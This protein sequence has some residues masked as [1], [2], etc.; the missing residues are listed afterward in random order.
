MIYTVVNCCTIKRKNKIFKFVFSF[1]NWNFPEDNPWQNNFRYETKDSKKITYRC[2]HD[3]DQKLT[4]RWVIIPQFNNPN[5]SSSNHWRRWTAQASGCLFVV[6]LM[7]DGSAIEER[8]LPEL[9]VCATAVVRWARHWAGGDD[10]I[11]TGQHLQLWIAAAYVTQVTG[12]RGTAWDR[13]RFHR[14]FHAEQSGDG[15]LVRVE[16]DLAQ[17]CVLFVLLGGDLL[18]NQLAH[19]TAVQ[20][21][22]QLHRVQIGVQVAIVRC[23]L[24]VALDLTLMCAEVPIQIGINH[25]YEEVVHLLQA[26]RIVQRLQWSDR[27]R[28]ASL[29]FQNVL[30]VRRTGRAADHGGAEQQTGADRT[31]TRE[32]I[33][34]NQVTWALLKD[35]WRKIS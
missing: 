22:D 1:S 2:S 20:V 33:G 27:L 29:I 4:K 21:V 11:R 24:D 15:G 7:V 28:L 30:Q 34:V 35:L 18:E 31:W 5:L 3:C 17:L 13:V 19:V 23:D 6:R 8:L 10:R 9:H 25:A 12:Q 26:Q 16:R 32:F 14:L